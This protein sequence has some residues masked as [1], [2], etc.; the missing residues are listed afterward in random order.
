M[1]LV[2]PLRRV[3]ESDCERKCRFYNNL[4]RTVVVAAVPIPNNLF[5]IEYDTQNK[6]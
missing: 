2:K 5:S 6:F 3:L 4:V 1:I